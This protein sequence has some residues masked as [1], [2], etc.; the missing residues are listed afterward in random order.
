LDNLTHSLVGA[1][2]GQTGLKKK[3]GLGMAA[4]VIGANIPDIDG[5][6]SLYGLESL[7]MRRGLTHGPIAWV[8]LPLALA[9]MLYGWDRWQARRGKRPDGRMPVRFGWLYALALIGCLTH[10]LMDWMN[11]YGIRFLEP[12]SSQWFY[13]DVLFIIDLW[14]WIGLGFATWFSLRREK[15]G[16][17]WR[18]PAVIAL[19]VLVAYLGGNRVLT[20]VTEAR[21]LGS[22]PYPSVVI[23]N[24]TPLAFWRREV[25]AGDGEG[26]WTVDGVALDTVPLASCDLDA[27]RNADPRAEAFLFWSRAPFISGSESDGWT[28]SDARFTSRIGGGNRFSISLPS[29]ACRSS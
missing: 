21:A 23:A 7:S 6:C 26:S 19:A 1:L 4:L 13:G 2:I 10:P 24:P 27:A 12:F 8:L 15:R 20:S 18:R 29:G 5:V 28:L 14:L 17:E 9:A 16:G 22:E 11:S 3:T 25:I